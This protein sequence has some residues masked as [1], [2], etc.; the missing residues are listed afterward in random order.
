[1]L[2][3]GLF[4]SQPSRQEN[5]CVQVFVRRRRADI[6]LEPNRVMVRA[7]KNESV[8]NAGPQTPGP[9]RAEF[10]LVEDPKE[11]IDSATASA[12]SKDQKLTQ[13]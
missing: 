11:E 13:L 9:A 6:Y 10:F 8:E 4:L 7:E 3:P 2:L 1:L 12:S 5:I